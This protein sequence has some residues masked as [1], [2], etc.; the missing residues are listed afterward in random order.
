VGSL[1]PLQLQNSFAPELAGKLCERAF[2]LVYLALTA[3]TGSLRLKEQVPFK[4][5]NKN[6]RYNMNESLCIDTM[7]DPY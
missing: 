7:F 5:E 1:L 6:Q 3:E 2:H 4:F